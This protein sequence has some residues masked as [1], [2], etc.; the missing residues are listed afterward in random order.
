MPTLDDVFRKFG[1]AAEAGQ[2]LETELGTLLLSVETAKEGLI[3]GDGIR[4]TEIMRSINRTTLGGLIRRVKVG[5]SLEEIELLLES[6]LRARNRLMHSFY[7]QH[8]FRKFS[9]EGRTIMMDDLE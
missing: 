1:E 4:A 7:R 6:A 8:N 3:E 2:L 9:E 5:Q